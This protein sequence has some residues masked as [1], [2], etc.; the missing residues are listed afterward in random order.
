MSAIK[1]INICDEI[2]KRLND[3]LI[4]AFVRKF[5]FD[6]HESFEAKIKFLRIIHKVSFR[7]AQLSRDLDSFINHDFLNIRLKCLKND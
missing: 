2:F 4:N 7:T 1:N 5:K 3:D 6:H